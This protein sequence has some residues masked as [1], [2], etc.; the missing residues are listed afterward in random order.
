MARGKE[1]RRRDAQQTKGRIL[2]VAFELFAE[3]GY[4]RTGTR[5]IAAAAG[6]APS[7]IARHFGS[8]AS[9]FEATLV[10]GIEEHSLFVDDKQDFGQRMAKLVVS[11]SN[12]KL[13]TMIILAT[14]DPQSAEIAQRVTRDHILKPLAKWLGPPQAN[15]RALNM[16]T[17]LNGFT[18]QSRRLTTGRVPPGSVRWFAQALQDIVDNK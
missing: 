16:L 10:Y 12:P 7:L 13:P 9:L 2:G 14:A 6:V 8:K 15:A 5:D 17:L 1:T 18:I 4:A 3:H 11:R